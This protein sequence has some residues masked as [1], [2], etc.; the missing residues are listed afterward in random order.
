MQIYQVKSSRGWAEIG[1]HR[2]FTFYPYWICM[3]TLSVAGMELIQRGCCVSLGRCWAG[4]KK[5][6]ASCTLQR[7]ELVG[8]RVS[9][10]KLKVP[11]GRFPRFPRHSCARHERRSVE[12]SRRVHTRSTFSFS[13]T[14]FK[15][16]RRPLKFNF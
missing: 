2:R 10:G 13:V 14:C 11:F 5:I 7:S 1:A 3:R 4:G 12:R 9:E 15:F 6:S 16:D 8:W